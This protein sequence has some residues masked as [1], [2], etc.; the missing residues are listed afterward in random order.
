M[1]K[2]GARIL[3]CLMLV[4]ALVTSTLTAFA[5]PNTTETPATEQPTS[6]SNK[7]DLSR[8]KSGD[9]KDFGGIAS[10]NCVYLSSDYNYLFLFEK[11]NNFYTVDF[12]EL[13]PVQGNINEY[14]K[15][16]SSYT[17]FMDATSKYYYFGDLSTLKSSVYG[18]NSFYILVNSKKNN[19]FIN[20]GKF[21]DVEDF[22]NGK[23]VEKDAIFNPSTEITEGVVFDVSESHSSDSA[24]I[25]VKYKAD[26]AGTP[27][28]SIDLF[29]NGGIVTSKDL[30]T[31]KLEGEQSFTVDTNGSYEV[32]L[33]KTSQASQ[34]SIYLSKSIKIEGLNE[35]KQTAPQQIVD[36]S[37]SKAYKKPVITFKNKPKSASD[38]STVTLT[39]KS[40]TKAVLNF[41]GKSSKEYV[42]S[43]KV[44]VSTNGT[45][46][47]RALGKGGKEV[48]GTLKV[49]F[50]KKPRAFKDEDRDNFWNNPNSPIS[51][52]TS[53]LPQTGSVG[54]Y[55]MIAFGVALIGVGGLVVF[56]A[57]KSR[58]NK[59]IE[60]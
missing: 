11:N 24:T 57:T 37:T 14:V 17:S 7:L 43:M 53:K 12:E 55:W 3:L 6:D 39:M 58:K 56:K 21:K 42:N 48:T 38:G 51:A 36:M 8:F 23:V 46:T 25:T 16:S 2:V 27:F 30:D 10:D 22:K 31:S 41:N 33:Y 35:R 47:Y 9:L 1:R 44:N 59:G 50:F 13:Y 28:L 26:G 5:E 40:S 15:S 34:K 52:I 49:N 18:S 20:L 54:W 19:D 32:Y 4:I 60:N 29:L 45:Y